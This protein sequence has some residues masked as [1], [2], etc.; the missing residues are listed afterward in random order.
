MV[1]YTRR[2]EYIFYKPSDIDNVFTKR[3]EGY[4]KHY[5]SFVNKYLYRHDPDRNDILLER[6]KGEFSVH[7]QIE[8]EKH[9]SKLVG[10]SE[11][12]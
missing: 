2:E 5:H 10:T 8:F 6:G 3:P 9:L 11:E 1:N 7:T 12:E 4:T